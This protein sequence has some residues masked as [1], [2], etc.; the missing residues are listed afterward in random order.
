MAHLTAHRGRDAALLAVALATA[1]AIALRW[2]GLDQSLF[3]DEMLTRYAVADGVGGVLGRLGRFEQNPPL[4][5]WLAAAGRSLGGVDWMRMPSLL[6]GAAAV[7]LT[8]ALGRLTTGCRSGVF[9]AG[10]VALSP[11]LAF[12]GTEARPYALMT[13]LL[14]ASAA[15]LLVAVERG[16]R[17]WWAG[18]VAA[19]AAALY[20]QYVAVFWLAAQGAWALWAAP[21]RRRSVIVAFALTTLAFLPWLPSFFDQRAATTLSEA[22]TVRGAGRTLVQLAFGHPFTTLGTSLGDAGRLA[23]A[24]VAAALAAGAILAARRAGR[25]RRTRPAGHP[26]ARSIALLALLAVATPIGLWAYAHL[27]GLSF[28][29]GRYWIA[30][31]P[32][33]LLLAGALLL[34]LPR[35][36]ALVAMVAA[37]AVAGTVAV[38]T[39]DG[40]LQRPQSKPAARFADSFAGPGVP[41]VEVPALARVTQTIAWLIQPGQAALIYGAIATPTFAHTPHAAS[42]AMYYRRAH[43]QYGPSGYLP[44]APPL[45]PLAPRAAWRRARTAGRVIVLSPVAPG[46]FEPPAPPRSLHARLARRTVWPGF[47]DI[48]AEEWVVPRRRTGPGG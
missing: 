42:Y 46:E 6:A 14:L 29:L 28:G 18:M 32:P 7:P 37:L 4:Y 45:R 47:A 33:A 8:Y 5:F 20:T 21:D 48:V 2:S 36:V 3:G 39:M 19:S 11:F 43:R 17:W 15:C 24:G 23:L 41:V 27:G 10:M 40:G 13:T 30:S 31:V 12:Y 9:A 26:S 16:G 44:V 38:R 35:P 25:G 22:I 1:A 34:E